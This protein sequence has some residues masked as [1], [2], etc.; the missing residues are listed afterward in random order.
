[1]ATIKRT[2]LTLVLFLWVWLVGAQDNHESSQTPV[3]LQ[4]FQ[5]IPFEGSP[6]NRSNVI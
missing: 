2:G 4:P 6:T 5:L 1:M 3:N